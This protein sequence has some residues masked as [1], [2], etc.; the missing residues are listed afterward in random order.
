MARTKPQLTEKQEAFAFEYMMN[1]RNASDAYRKTYGAKKLTPPALW[2]EA[3]RVLHSTKVIGRVGELQREQYSGDIMKIEERKLALTD[4]GRLKGIEAV[5][6]I[7]MLNKMDGIY[8]PNRE[9]PK[10]QNISIQIIRDNQ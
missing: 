5:K 4:L 9:K 1:G 7:D 8:D 10:E 2:R 6:A 3:H